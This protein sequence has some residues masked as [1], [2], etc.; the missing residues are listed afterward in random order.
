MHVLRGASAYEASR[1]F[2]FSSRI[3]E[4]W[5]KRLAS[6]GLSGLWDEKHSGRP[7]RI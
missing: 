2:G 7:S 3:I 5:V 6:D 1:A 4:Y